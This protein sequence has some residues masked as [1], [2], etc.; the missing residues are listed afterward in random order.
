MVN[1]LN[2]QFSDLYAAQFFQNYT[3]DDEVTGRYKNAG[4]LSYIRIFGAGHEV[5]AYK[6]GNLGYGVA[7]L[8][9]FEQVMSGGPLFP[10]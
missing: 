5:P 3:V 7:A 6:F 1:N 9:M 4:T 8:Q 10:T 2:T